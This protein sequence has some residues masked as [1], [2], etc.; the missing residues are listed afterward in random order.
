MSTFVE[1]NE[2]KLLAF[3]LLSQTVGAR[4]DYVQGGGG[5][6]SVKLDGRLMAIKASG[7]CLSDI[8]ADDA[9]AVLD[10]S[11]VRNFYMSHAVT[12]FADVEKAGSDEVKQSVTVPEGLSALRPSVEAGFHSLLDTFVVH[13]HSVYANLASCCANGREI[14][15]AALKDADYTFGFVPYV[16]PGARL[17]YYIRDELARVEKETGK[18]PS[19]ILMQNHGIIAHNDDPEKCLEIHA[20]A[21]E[22]I[23]AYFGLTGA[24]FPKVAIREQADGSFLSDTPYLA[25]PLKGTEYSDERLLTEPLYP[26]Q[27]VFFTGTLGDTASIDRATGKASYRM[28]AKQ[29][30]TMEETLTAVV[31]IMEHIKEHGYQLSTMGEAAKAFIANWESEKYRKSL[32]GGKK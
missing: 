31:F 26:D 18:R 22:R 27:M 7:Y 4:N 19:V 14:L 23:A 21:N 17:T 8:R 16:D 25:A 29:A 20:D 5:N 3:S 9:Y 2:K 12:D 11:R 13:S 32:V 28:P 30:L 10:Y 15:A 1:Q 6:T 24:S